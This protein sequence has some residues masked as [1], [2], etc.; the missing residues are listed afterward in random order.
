MQRNSAHRLARPPTPALNARAMLT[1]H[2]THSTLSRLVRY[3]ATIGALGLVTAG[4]W[5]LRESIGLLNIGLIYLIVVIGATVLAGR[6]AGILA[7]LLGFV[8]F[9]YFLVPPYLTFVIGDQRDILALFVFLG[10]SALLSWLIAG[11]RE[12]AQQAQRRAADVSRLY[13]LSQAII[14]TQRLEDVLPAIAHKV[15][16]VFS[17]Q[18]A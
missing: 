16:E 11:A 13:E 6:N 9:N 12:Q 1:R 8:L 4:L 18:V 7:S 5:P 3:G 2:P 14:G 15:R 17:V 10:V